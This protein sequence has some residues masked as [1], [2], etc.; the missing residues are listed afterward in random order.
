MN[1]KS[2][3]NQL[4]QD[5]L[6]QQELDAAYNEANGITEET[7]DHN[8]PKASN[9]DR[10]DVVNDPTSGTDTTEEDPLADILGDEQ[11]KPTDEEDTLT[12]ETEEDKKQ[13]EDDYVDLEGSPEDDDEGLIRPDDPVG[14][15][16]RIGKE[17]Q[18]RKA[19]EATVNEIKT[20][21]E[22]LM[23]MMMGQAP[24]MNMPSAM[25]PNQMPGQVPNQSAQANVPFVP[26]ALPKPYEEMNEFERFEYFNAY[27]AAETQAKQM[28]SQQRAVQEKQNA[29]LK[30]IQ[31]VLAQN[32][33]D[34]VIKEL[35]TDNPGHYTQ[36]MLIP[37]ADYPNAASLT[38]HLHLKHNAELAVLKTKSPEEQMRGIVRLAERTNLERKQ[39][40]EK[41]AQVKKPVPAG[42]LKSATLPNTQGK[43]DI[44]DPQFLEKLTPKQWDQ[45]VAKGY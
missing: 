44:Y 19:L 35:Y 39:A 14:V 30:K 5:E 41:K 23:R 16:K 3:V 9:E 22:M 10:E 20:Q 31:S 26:P 11:Q 29:S 21:N 40:F 43:K 28:H 17:V 25:M 34:P 38:R 13:P 32:L 42:K 1:A 6:D 15:Q 8:E 7:K 24:Q 37:L 33:H 12:Q 4:S 27:K 18:R 2:N 45:L 36:H